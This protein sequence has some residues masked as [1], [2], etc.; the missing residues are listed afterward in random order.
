M[1]SKSLKSTT[2]LHLDRI[3]INDQVAK[4]LTKVCCW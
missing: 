4:M 1:I 2:L 3:P